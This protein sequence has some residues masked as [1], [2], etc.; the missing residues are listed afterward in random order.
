MAAIPELVAATV[1]TSLAAATVDSDAEQVHSVADVQLPAGDPS[2]KTVDATSVVLGKE[3][4]QSVATRPVFKRV[5]SSGPNTLSD[6]QLDDTSNNTETP[7]VLTAPSTIQDV[8]AAPSQQMF[9]YPPSEIEASASMVPQQEDAPIRRLRMLAS[10]FALFLAGWNGGSVGAMIPHI[11]KAFGIGYIQVSLLFV[12]TFVGYV[13]AAVVAGTLSRT[14]G[15][16]HA[17]SIAVLVELIGNVINSSQQVNF[18]LMC[19]GFFVVGCAFATQ[20][21]LCN[22]YFAA[23]DKPLL[24]TGIL[25]GIYGL[26][27]FASP[28]V[29]T[30]MVSRGVPYHFFYTTNVGMNVPVFALIW[31][32]FHNLH[33]IPQPSTQPVDPTASTTS[34]FRDALKSR[35]VWTLSIFLMLYVGAEESI[36]GWIVTYILDVRNGSP[37][38]AS[39]VASAFYLGIAIGR[40]VLPALNMFIGERRAVFLYLLIA[41]ALEILA[42]FVPIY[43]S[44]AICTAL[45]GLAISTFYAAAITIGGKLIPRAMHADAFSLMSSVGQSGSALWPLVVALL[46]TKRGIWVVEPTVVALLGAQGICW[47]LVPR[48]DRRLD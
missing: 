48:V 12:C 15:F 26:G 8:S 43:A 42:W 11:E 38:G 16:G 31:I 18:S 25:H 39:W 35:A 9:L 44:T 21:G 46:S 1:Q 17:L 6:A 32:A 14:V 33:T 30:A 4:V 28:L 24:W 22:A 13:V 40:I 34:T 7:V 23:L 20:L 3:N 2:P 19:F 29:A 41:I 36:G 10:F 37:E 45:V 5:D 27:A 47:W